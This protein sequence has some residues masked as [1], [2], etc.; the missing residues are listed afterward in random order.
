MTIYDN[1]RDNYD[2]YLTNG[3]KQEIKNVL[4]LPVKQGL[5]MEKHRR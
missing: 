1:S 5:S 4:I 3:E 2:Y